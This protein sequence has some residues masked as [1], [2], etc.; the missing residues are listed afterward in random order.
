MFVALL[1]NLLRSERR[2]DPS[3]TT[4]LTALLALTGLLIA[5][6]TDNAI[7]YPFV[8][9]PVGVLVGAGLGARAYGSAPVRV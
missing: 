6:I 3:A 4:H 5:C 9:T 2:H 7:I 8:M 1:R